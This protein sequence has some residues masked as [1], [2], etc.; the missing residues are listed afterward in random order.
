MVISLKEFA[1][2]I[3]FLGDLKVRATAGTLNSRLLR[4][5]AEEGL[6]GI[7][8]LSGVPGNTGGAVYMNAGTGAGWIDQAI[9]SVEAMNLATGAGRTLKKSELRYSYRQQH[10][11]SPT[12]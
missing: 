11:W 6:C 2:A 5:T 3:D 8:A 1:P 7:E 10:F 12:K 4:A 9:V